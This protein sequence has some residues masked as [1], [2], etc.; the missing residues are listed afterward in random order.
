MSHSHFAW[1]L[2]IPTA[3]A[4]C[5]GG[6]APS[7]DPEPFVITSPSTEIGA[8]TE[9]AY[10]YYF[11]LPNTSQAA[12]RRLQATLGAGV[13]RTNVIFTD[14]DIQTP[15]TQ[16][17]DDCLPLVA[18]SSQGQ[19]WAYSAYPPAEALTF[20]GDD[21][22]GKPVGRIVSPGQSGYLYIHYL[23]ATD[24]PIVSHVEVEVLPYA[25]GTVVTPANSFVAYNASISISPASTMSFSQAC[26]V[27]EDAK[28]FWMSTYSHK[29]MIDASITDGMSTVFESTDPFAPGKVVWNGPFFT[30]ASGEL[31]Y[32]FD[33]TNP[34][35]RTITTGPSFAT[36]ELGIA[37]AYF[38]PAPTPHFC[39]DGYPL[40]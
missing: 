22:A 32:T 7:E 24:A 29:Q 10:C 35:N 13:V 26:G 1:L 23:N 30:F 17:S 4:A 9:V 40:L 18:A 11:R 33:Y 28:F 3:V 5:G 6:S 19:A 38:F 20:P 21:G 12:I 39:V 36:D 15:G 25:Q 37:L 14:T 8:G 16:S 2:L 31:R 34:S 27:P